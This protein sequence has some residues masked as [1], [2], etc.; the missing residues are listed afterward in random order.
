MSSLALAQGRRVFFAATA[1]A[2]VARVGA[3]AARAISTSDPHAKGNM[4]KKARQQL[5]RQ[6]ATASA[7]SAAGSSSSQPP[8]PS[9]SESQTSPNPTDSP[10]ESTSTP[11]PTDTSAAGVATP[12]A[13]ESGAAAA[14]PA[15]ILPSLDFHAT[16][17][18]SPAD[19]PTGARSS[20]ESLS[21]IERRRRFL[22][23]VGL[24]ILGVGLVGAG[25]Y[26][27]REWEDNED[28]PQVRFALVN[29]CESAWNGC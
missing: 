25:V 29:S 13:A 26:M 24:T 4:S 9:E 22:G 27:G 16:I 3:V 8:S 19:R 20:K 6:A 5:Q 18:E 21:T 1:A 12:V 15:T 28:I 7:S 14:P 2:S 10:A 23:R 17:P 11:P